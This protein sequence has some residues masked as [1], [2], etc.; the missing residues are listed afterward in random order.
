MQLRSIKAKT[1]LLIMPL[2]LVIVIGVSSVVIFKSHSLL[3]EQTENSMQEQLANTNQ[4]IQNRITSHGRVP[5]TLARSIQSHY[6][7]LTLEDYDAILKNTL[8]VNKDTFG[9]GVY[10]EPHVYNNNIKYVSSYAYHEQNQITVT[11]DYNDPS[12]NYPAKE[13]YKTAVNQKETQYTDPFYDEITKSI[14]VTA[15]VPVYDDQQ[16]F[17]GVTA[18]DINLDTV[19]TIV[20]ETEVGVS[21]WAFMLDKNGTYLAGP[22]PEKIMKVKLQEDKDPALSALA[23][24]ILQEGK[25]AATYT[26]SEG[27]VHVY[28]SKLEQT[29]WIVAV[30]LPDQELKEKINALLLQAAMFLII[31]MALIVVVILLYTRNLTAHTTRVNSM[32]E[33]LAQGDF[34]YSIEVKTKDEF[35]KMAGNLNDTS[36]LLNTMMAKVTEHSLHVASTS[37]ELT[38]SADQTSTVAEDIANTIQEVAIGAETQL[39]GTQESARSLE[40]LAIGIQ[41]ISE[42]SS[43]LYDASQNTSRQAEQGNEIIQQA[44]RDMNE[45]NRSVLVTAAHMNQLR[46]RSVDIGNI[47]NVISG[48]ST[49]TNLLSLNA[50]IEAARAGEHGRGF[51]VVATEIRKLSEQTK[52]SAEKVREIIE[53]MQGETEAAVQSVEIGTKAVHSSTVLVEHAGE[54]FT[55][56]VMEIQ[57]I[58]NQIQEVSSVSEQM[59]AG[60]QQ[61]SATMEDLARI[62]GEASD[63][64]QSVAAASEQQLASMEE[65]SASAKSLSSMVQEL[66][67]LLEQFKMK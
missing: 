58:V 19:Q 64:T 65:V 21:G 38:A 27:L 33:H 62:S 56:I 41:R 7:K 5:E 46:D 14:M 43:S 15:S 18:G 2:L 24:T 55:G 3:L 39:V 53:E 36:N 22:Q 28:F 35:G 23:N 59:S 66:Q 45:A 37:E 4:S 25:G 10:F 30:A 44:V 8:D 51:A 17:I 6:T 47:I 12:Y 49:Q 50:G 61:I 48:I 32:A 11:H 67:N 16:R 29:D 20:S 9:V 42:S 54:A 52:R 60:S 34:T 26:S 31:G 1:L 57:Q 13:W 40:E 63:A